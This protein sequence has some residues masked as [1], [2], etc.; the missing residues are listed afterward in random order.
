MIGEK[1]D[2]CPCATCPEVRVFI[3]CWT[4]CQAERDWEARQ[5]LKKVVN[6]SKRRKVYCLHCNMDLIANPNVCTRS[7]STAYCE[8]GIDGCTKCYVTFAECSECREI[9]SE[10]H[11]E[12]KYLHTERDALERRHRL[13]LIRIALLEGSNPKEVSKHVEQKDKT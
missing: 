13:V 12:L 2:L 10:D 5:L 8:E 9:M 4:G 6:V 7:G 11:L 1:D 3:P